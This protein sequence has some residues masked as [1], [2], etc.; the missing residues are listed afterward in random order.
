MNIDGDSDRA[1]SATWPGGFN[2]AVD[3][4]RRRL[5]SQMPPSQAQYA[6]FNG[7]VDEHRRRP[8]GRSASA[9]G[10]DASMEPSMN[11]D[12][13]EPEVLGHA[14]VLGLQWSRR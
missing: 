10:I 5:R 11:I 8:H 3:E 6:G 9:R 4:H 7:A 1:R 13:D 2:G 12:G 14:G